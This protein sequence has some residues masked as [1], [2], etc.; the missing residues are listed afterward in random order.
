MLKIGLFINISSYPLWDKYLG[1]NCYKYMNITER[2]QILIIC[3][4]EIKF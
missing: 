4:R 2:K 1:L 3:R